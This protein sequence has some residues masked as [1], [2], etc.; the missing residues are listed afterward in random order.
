MPVKAEP[1]AEIDV[2]L[3][4]KVM[5]GGAGVAKANAQLPHS[6]DIDETD[7]SDVSSLNLVPPKVINFQRFPAER[8]PQE[9]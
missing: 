3:E 5:P 4:L 9:N 8:R 2:E 7:Y 6:D 1:E